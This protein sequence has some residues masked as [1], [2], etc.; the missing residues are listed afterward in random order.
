MNSV[1]VTGSNGG[2]GSAICNVLKNKGYFVIGSDRYDD[3]NNLD[4]FIKFDIRDLAV[5]ENKRTEFLSKLVNLIGETS[6]KALINNAAVQILSS[7]DDLI[8]D[9][10]RESLDTNLVAP[11]SL[12]KM[13]YPF[14]KESK[15][16]IVNIGS[17]H[18]KLTKPG[19]ISYATSKSAL[20]GLTQSMSV[21]CGEFVR[22]NAIQPA[23]TATEML[24]DGFKD[25]PKAFEALKA[26][27]PTN[28]IAAPD[29]VAQAVCFVISEQCQFLNGSVLDING[30]IGARLHDPV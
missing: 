16:S 10:F 27:H 9:D 11:L 3:I 14:L 8:V 18:S 2:I 13:A 25:N 12:S 6:F 5:L 4:G 22:V 24:L 30:G 19:F 21:D 28:S 29:E 17:I 7:I 15:G 20:L 26:F 1:L 23:A